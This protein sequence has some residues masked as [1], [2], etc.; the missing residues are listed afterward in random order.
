MQFGEYV[1]CLLYEHRK[2]CGQG[3]VVYSNSSTVI[4]MR[5]NLKGSSKTSCPLPSRGLAQQQITKERK[6]EGERGRGVEEREKESVM[7]QQ[8]VLLSVRVLQRSR[9][10]RTHIYMCYMIHITIKGNIMMN[11]LMQLWRMR[12][13]MICLL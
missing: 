4:S 12:S 2:Q 8:R 6:E 11:W 5:L 10:N 9:A 7:Y 3:N 1:R 13:S